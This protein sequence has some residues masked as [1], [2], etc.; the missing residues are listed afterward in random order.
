MAKM[1]SELGADVFDDT[2][3]VKKS[4]FTRKQKN[5]MIGLPIVG[6][7]AIA[8]GLVYTLAANVW[9][10]DYENMAYITYSVSN[11][12]DENGEKTAAINRVLP[13]SGY[14]ANFRIPAE[15]NGTKITEIKEGAFAGCTRLKKITMTDNIVKI[16]EQA[17]AGCEELGSFKFSKNINYIG[18]E[19]FMDTKFLANLPTDEVVS[20]NSVLISVGEELLGSKTALV[21]KD[22]DY[23]TRFREYQQAGYTLF[24]MDALTKITDL[25]NLPESE[26]TITQWMEGL[27]DGS[28]SIQLVEIPKA[29]TH[30]PA[31][32]FQ[33]CYNIKEVLIHNYVESIGEKAFEGCANL[34]DIDIPT[35]VKSIGDYAFAYTGA[36]V[37]SIPS[38][39]ET[40]GT[41]VF[42]GCT[43]VTS[44]TIPSTLTSIPNETFDGCSNLSSIIF[45]DATKITSFGTHAFAGTALTNFTFPV[46]VSTVAEGLFQGC[47]LLENVYMY[48]NLNKV[49]V[50]GSDPED[51]TYVGINNIYGF[52]FE[53]CTNLKSIKLYDDNGDVLAKCSDD[54]TLYLPSTLLRCSS[55][56]SSTSSYNAFKGVG[57][58][59]VVFPKSLATIGISMF[60]DAKNLETVTFEDIANSNL[61]LVDKSAFMNCTSLKN[62]TFPNRTS[63]IG[64]SV[65]EGC[66]SLETVHLPEVKEVPSEIASEYK[67]LSVIKE[68]LFYNCTSLHTVNVPSSITKISDYSFNNCTALENI[69]IPIN[70]TS[71]TKTAFKGCVNTVV[72][73]EADKQPSKWSSGWDA[74]VKEV[75]YGQTA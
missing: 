17:F 72:S 7:L 61:S 49:E 66:T 65:F 52:A 23:Q 32:S 13:D 51:P 37:S 8:L 64:T 33:N 58:K 3:V 57:A 21:T 43:G 24:D 59:A 55:S 44:F 68:R 19:A 48:E 39:I 18:K 14:P 62:F 12:L 9:L 31:K 45:E 74:D 42:Q 35:N 73:V 50:E 1:I 63:S 56:V 75:K 34:V 25:N 2:V 67:P 29:L 27:F 20:V 30:V 26:V 40:L 15:I 38:T 11:K 22:G 6:V 36:E 4:R 47:E 28:S 69:F 70:V 5:Y 46:N 10:I 54:N 60:E 41:G 53:N 16:G 71:V